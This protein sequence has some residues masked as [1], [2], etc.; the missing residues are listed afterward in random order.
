MYIHTHTERDTHS[1][2]LLFYGDQSVAITIDYPKWLYDDPAVDL[3]ND[4]SRAFLHLLD[5]V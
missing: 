4:Y 5:F 1:P 2:E 3:L